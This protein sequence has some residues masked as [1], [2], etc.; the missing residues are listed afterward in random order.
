MLAH[1]SRPVDPNHAEYDGEQ[2]K[3]ASDG[4][5][6]DLY[7]DERRGLITHIVVRPGVTAIQEDAF[8]GCTSLTSIAL[9]EGLDEIGKMAFEGCTSL[10]SISF[11]E[12]LTTIGL[13]AFDTCTSLSSVILPEGLA[14][15]GQGA[16]YGCTSLTSISIPESVPLVYTPIQDSSDDDSDE[17]DYQDGSSGVA[18]EAFLDC[19]LLSQLSAA[20][21]MSVEQFLRWRRR[22]PSQRY[23]VQAALLRLRTEL[24]E[25]QRKRARRAVEE[26]GG[27]ESVEEEEEEEEEEEA[28]Y[29][30]QELQGK[31]AFDIITSEDVWRHILEFL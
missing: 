10:S 17:D 7:D 30:A 2:L 8:R 6:L 28:Q 22:V 4:V 1:P 14:A 31:L 29:E 27:G 25:R 11:P 18:P 16:F 24:Y 13:G 20:K 3:R 15:I 12:G 5:V 21:S 26:V 9:P 23:A 19:T